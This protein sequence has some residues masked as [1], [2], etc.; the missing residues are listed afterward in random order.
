MKK[1][2][3]IAIEHFANQ[4]NRKIIVPEWKDDTGKPI[5][6]FVSPMTLAEKKRLYHGSKSDDVSILADCII[7]KAEDQK[8][9]KLFSVNDKQDLMYKVDPDVLSELAT[10]IMSAPSPEEYE[11]N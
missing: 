3:D 10:K 1:V 9:A 4:G 8:G 2:L 11:K 6:V 7:M 5:E